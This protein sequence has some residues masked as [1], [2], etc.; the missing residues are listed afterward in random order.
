LSRKRNA[1]IPPSIVERNA[2]ILIAIIIVA[3]VRI[4]CV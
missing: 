4:Y 2:A 3:P 1:N